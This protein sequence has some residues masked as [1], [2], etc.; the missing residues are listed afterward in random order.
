[1]FGA[2]TIGD[3]PLVSQF[4]FVDLAPDLTE[5][6]NKMSQLHNHEQ[7]PEGPPVNR[8]DRQVGIGRVSKMS[9][10]GATHKV[11][12][13]NRLLYERICFSVAPSALAIF[14]IHTPSSRSGLLTV[15]L[16]GL[17]EVLQLARDIS[18][19]KKLGNEWDSSDFRKRMRHYAYPFPTVLG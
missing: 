4:I 14:T 2:L 7:R 15:G 5:L 11:F 16:S 8:P 18:I 17:S 1:M 6:L 12:S 19:C 9:A 10:K 3:V 13:I